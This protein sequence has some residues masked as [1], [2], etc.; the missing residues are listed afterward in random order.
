MSEYIKNQKKL[1]ICS[2]ELFYILYFIVLYT[3]TMQCIYVKTCYL[4]NYAADDSIINLDYAF[5][6]DMAKNKA[7]LFLYCYI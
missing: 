3:S 2:S 4:R 6:V 1:L 7:L 5:Q